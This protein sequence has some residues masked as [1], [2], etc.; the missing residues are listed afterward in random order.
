MLKRIGEELGATK[1]GLVSVDCDKEGMCI[2]QFMRI[3]VGIE[4][5][6]L[7]TYCYLCGK[8]DHKCVHC[9]QYTVGHNDEVK[10][11]LG[12]G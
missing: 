10:S 12:Y 1:G 11:S 6:R 2:G 5:E 8:M 9:H 7:S 4:Y 3:K